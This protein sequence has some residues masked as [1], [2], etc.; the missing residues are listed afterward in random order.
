MMS[1]IERHLGVR[2]AAALMALSALIAL[3]LPACAGRPCGEM[4]V[5]MIPGAALTLSGGV[6]YGNRGEVFALRA[7]DGKL[8]WHT[9]DAS[10]SSS[11]Y[12]QPAAPVVDGQTV[13]AS[14]GIGGAAAW[15][16][17]DGKPM[18]R[19]QALPGVAPTLSVPEPPPVV[20]GGVVYEAA[21]YGS[22][23]AWDEGDGHLLWMSHFAPQSAADAGQAGGRV[24]LPL[25]VVLDDAVYVSIGT[26]LYSLRSEDGAVLWQLPEPARGFPYSTPT[27]VAPAGALYVS[28]ADGSVTRLDPHTGAQLWRVRDDLAQ[29]DQLILANVVASGATVYI[30]SSDGTARALSAAAGRQLWRTTLGDMDQAIAFPTLLDGHVFVA[31]EHGLFMLD[32]TTG[33]LVWHASHDL[34]R[35]DPVKVLS[36]PEVDQ[37]MIFLED[38]AGRLEAWRA[39]NGSLAWQFDQATSGYPL[40]GEGLVFVSRWGWPAVCGNP[41]TPPQVLALRGSDGSQVW[42]TKA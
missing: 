12:Q 41:P 17:S 11:L 4:S 2:G 32:V 39:G 24:S 7:S 42:A 31:S 28:A 38:S 1:G 19:T 37:G 25:P 35:V 6:V 29:L 34:G 10:A 22:V 40:A 30:S 36:S 21:G 14:T 26:A 27:P 3:A 9:S 18:W 8:L 15:R 33:R 23:A 5:A 16:A 20:S 13:I